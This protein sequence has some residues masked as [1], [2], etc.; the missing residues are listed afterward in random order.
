[1][2]NK[3]LREIIEELLRYEMIITGLLQKT[4]QPRHDMEDLNSILSPEKVM[5]IFHITDRSLRRMEQKG[6]LVPCR[7]GARKYYLP[8]DIMQVLR[9][10]QIRRNCL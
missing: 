7:L 5:E 9:G 8:S 6:L 10:S 3:T 4:F 1:M 2:T